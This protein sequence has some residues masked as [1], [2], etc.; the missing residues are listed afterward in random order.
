MSTGAQIPELHI[1]LRKRYPQ[2]AH[3]PRLSADPASPVPELWE[4][5]PAPAEPAQVLRTASRL[6][7]RGAG[8]HCP[9]LDVCVPTCGECPGAKLHSVKTSCVERPSAEWELSFLD[10]DLRPGLL[11][12]V[13][14]WTS[15]AGNAAHTA[16]LLTLRWGSSPA[17]VL[18]GFEP[19]ATN[20]TA[21]ECESLAVPPGTAL[22]AGAQ[23]LLVGAANEAGDVLAGA[24]A[25]RDRTRPPAPLSV[26]FKDTDARERIASGTVEMEPPLDENGI[27]S[28]R[29]V[30]IQW[31]GPRGGRAVVNWESAKHS[32]T[33]PGK[34][35]V[36]SAKWMP[37]NTTGLAVVSV[38]P[39]G[40]YS[41]PTG[42]LFNDFVR[43]QGKTAAPDA[44]QREEEAERLQAEAAKHMLKTSWSLA[45]KYKKTPKQIPEVH[46]A[47]SLEELLV[48]VRF[49]DQGK[50]AVF[51]LTGASLEGQV[52][53]ESLQTKDAK[54]VREAF[55]VKLDDSA[56]IVEAVAFGPEGAFRHKLQ[57]KFFDTL[58][59]AGSESDWALYEKP[60]GV[61]EFHIRLT[62]RWP[63]AWP[64]LAASPEA[65]HAERWREG[66]ELLEPVQ[67][68][69]TAESIAS[70]ALNSGM[71]YCPYEDVCQDHCSMCQDSTVE[72]LGRCSVDLKAESTDALVAE[73]VDTDARPQTIGGILRL[74]AVDAPRWARLEKSM[75]AVSL[76][77][78]GVDD[79]LV[80]GA[81]LT[82]EVLGPQLRVYRGTL[83]PEGAHSIAVLAEVG[84]ETIRVAVAAV[85]DVGAH[86]AGQVND[87]L[88]EPDGF[89]WPVEWDEQ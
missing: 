55:R 36:L 20:R 16:D 19:L 33:P 40:A 6:T 31:H 47:Q 76:H 73:F 17:Q 45:K 32:D 74:D 10:T 24:V 56:L 25:I 57:V 86:E 29:V 3:W 37:A 51:G 4:A 78:V 77:W 15:V 87:T 9:Q 66:E 42:V 58:L 70:C 44:R 52:T 65:L 64:R 35:I 62:K 75:K 53:K 89:Q 72:L 84:A 88:E 2:S 13:V 63:R 18:D 39:D 71:L 85:E 46:W 1:Q 34:A 8:F 54:A 21:D 60:S 82:T 50:L 14:N 12:G 23:Y 26:K 68:K 61:P 30:F 41:K 49:G 48:V 5:M 69:E 83:L 59:L 38:Y 11:G 80:P 43:R 27:E 67:E 28:Y 22:P 79:E 81:F 7:C